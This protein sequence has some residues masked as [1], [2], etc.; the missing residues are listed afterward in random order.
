MGFDDM[1]VEKLAWLNLLRRVGAGSA[2]EVSTSGT[3]ED[4]NR[5][6]P[7]DY[8]AGKKGTETAYY[9]YGSEYAVNSV[10][11]LANRYG[12]TYMWKEEYERLRER[13]N[14]TQVPTFALSWLGRWQHRF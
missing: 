3:E 5:K 13:T 8:P 14:L 6:P 10:L 7:V 1:I 9:R 2:I 12:H 11:H 4:Q